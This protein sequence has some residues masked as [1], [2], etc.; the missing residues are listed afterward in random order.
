MKSFCCIINGMLYAFWET[1][2]AATI[3]ISPVFPDLQFILITLNTCSPPMLI[4]RIT[5]TILL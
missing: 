5:A 4:L 1:V 2:S 3:L